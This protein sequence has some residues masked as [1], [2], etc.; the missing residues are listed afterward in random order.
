MSAT[1]NGEEPRRLNIPLSDEVLRSLT[2]GD[3]VL[4]S[5]TIYTARD[6]AHERFA[7]AIERGEPLPFDPQGQVLYFVG[8]TP[9]PPGKPI[10][11][12]G[13][14]T[15]SRMDPYSPLLIERGLSAMIGKGRR[16]APVRESMQQHG[17]VYFGAVE[18]HAAMLAQCIT[19]ADVIAYED[20]GAEAVFRLEVVDFP[21]IVVN[22]LHG[23][24]QYES[25]PAQ[26]RRD[27]S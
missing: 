11:A 2:S 19:A 27:I 20:L 18:G 24:D 25:G 23:G 12:A 15:A 13:P 8:P 9:A 17:C 16:S 10:G 14:T 21:A 22:D 1:T 6:A 26:W 3:S 5:G 4:L 7:S